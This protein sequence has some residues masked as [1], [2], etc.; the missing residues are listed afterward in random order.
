MSIFHQ[1]QQGSY[2]RWHSINNLMGRQIC[3]TAEFNTY[4]DE[5]DTK[6]KFEVKCSKNSQ[7]FYNN[8]GDDNIFGYTMRKKG[9]TTRMEGYDRHRKSPINIT[10]T[11][12]LLGAFVLSPGHVW[13]IRYIDNKWRVID[14]LNGSEPEVQMN[15]FQNKGLAFIF[16][17]R[18]LDIMNKLSLED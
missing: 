9:I 6:N 15:Y 10:D 16:V 5:L 13:C 18:D 11:E 4:C 8:G 14:S 12:D 7:E 1:R 3:T 17:W 2:C